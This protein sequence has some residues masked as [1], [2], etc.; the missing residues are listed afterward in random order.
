MCGCVLKYKLPGR[1]FEKANMKIYKEHLIHLLF[2]PRCPFCDRVMFT[3]I[4]LPPEMVCDSCSR[5][6]EYVQEP[7]CKKCGKPL[8]DEQQEYCY[9]CIHQ[10]RAFIQGKALWVYQGAVRESISRFKYNGRQEYAKYY[11]GELLRVHGE[12]IKRQGI[13]ALVPI[14]L[15]RQRMRQRGFNQAE[16]IARELSV[17]SK[18]PEYGKLLVR[19]RDTRAQKE[20][21]D[22]ERKNNLKKAFKTMS[23]KV[24]LYHILLIDD[25]Y[26]TGSTMNEAA[27][28]L[29]RAGAKEVYC[30]SVSI[31]R[32]YQEE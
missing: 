25:I 19:V 11:A 18:I 15:S 6:P 2:P 27:E 17:Q 12:W 26:T 32:G 10:R 16:L 20:L 8:D 31:G 21:N 4:F 23:N 13:D 9:D 22:K 1:F 24:Q 28:E 14:P 29:K 7:V 30:L 3:S 5:L